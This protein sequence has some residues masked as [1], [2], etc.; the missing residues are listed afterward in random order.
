[1]HFKLVTVKLWIR[2]LIH[3]AATENVTGGRCL[4]EGGAC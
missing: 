4:L 2:F 1:M 3:T